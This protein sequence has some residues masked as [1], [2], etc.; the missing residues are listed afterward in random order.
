MIIRQLYTN[1]LAQA[2][3]YIRSGEEAAVV[4]PIRDVDHYLALAAEDKAVIRYVLVTHFHADFISGQLEL[5]ERTGAAIVFGPRATPGYAARVM[6][7]GQLLPLGACTI[8]VLHTPGHTIESTCYLLHNAHH[9]PCALFS[10]DTL[11]VGDVG[12]PDLLSGNLG[13]RE[14]AAMLYDSI[15]N[16]LRPLP[17]EVL[18]YPGHGAGSACGKNLGKETWSTLGK[19]KKQNPA[20]QLS[21]SAFID[22]ITTDQPLIPAYFFKDASLNK[23]GAEPLDAVLERSM[24]PLSAERFRQELQ[25]GAMVLDT[26]SFCYPEHR[27]VEG[28]LYIGLDGQFAIWA[29]TL[30]DFGQPLL[31]VSD[32]GTEQEVIT[33]L[34]RIG[35]DT[36]RG[37]LD[38][39]MTAW[40]GPASSIETIRMQELTDEGA[41]R[42][43]YTLLDVRRV[44]ELDQE[45]VP[46]AVNIPL[47][48]LPKRLDELDS[49]Q[50]YAVFCAAGY[51]SRIAVS[52]LQQAGFGH[53]CSIAGGIAAIKT[54]SP[55]FVTS[56]V[57]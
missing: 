48:E 10:G 55:A 16:K 43:A 2:S 39:G 31:L 47:E 56:T 6:T 22:A 51:R 4:D 50:R 23:T 42:D 7:D 29:G 30:I 52:I 28:G 34:A 17:D 5:A 1:C 46:V 37:Y 36:C 33:R 20:F 8:R 26:R 41:P 49:T 57:Q 27:I 18:V 35:I 40:E 11:F 53:V 25:A 45:Q 44:A 24:R 12:R 14:L 3:Y 54:T 32:P 21:R 15:D 19:Q 9:E 13:A 38:G